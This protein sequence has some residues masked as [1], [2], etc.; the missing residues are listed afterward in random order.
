[1]NSDDDHPHS[2]PDDSTHSQAAAGGSDEISLRAQALLHSRA[3]EMAANAVMI[4]DRSGRISWVNPA[5]MT[6]TGYS[7]E[8]VRGRN[9]RLLKSGKHSR[10]YYASL[11]QTILAGR[12]WRG[13][14][15]NRRKDGSDYWDEHT[16][17]PVRTEGG[18]ITH[19]VAIM[20]DVTD[21][22]RAER[23]VE[24]RTR[25]ALLS[26]EIA[27]AFTRAENL[28]D[29]LRRCTD[30]IAL[31]LQ[32]SLVRV[33]TLNTA[34]NLLEM[35]ASS[36]L[37][38]ALDGPYSRVP[39]GQPK[40]G[41]VALERRPLYTDDL[42]HDP[43]FTNP[44]WA[45]RE[46]LTSFAAY[47]L[48]VHDQLL[49]VVAIFAR[50]PLPEFSRRGLAAVADQMAVGL[51]HSHALQ[52]LRES[53]E[54]YRDLFESANDLIQST[55]PHGFI[56]YAN[57]AWRETLGYQPEDLGHLRFLDVVHPDAR[58]EAEELLARANRGEQIKLIE[59]DFITR[60]RSRIAVEGSV[61]TKTVFGR[62]VSVRCIFRNVTDKK[63]LET[64]FLRH[65]RMESLG[66]LAGGIA[67]DL[68]N[69]LAPIL[70][71]VGLLRSKFT[72]PESQ[73]ILD[74][75]GAS[76]QR[77]ADMVKQVLTFSRGL[78]GKRAPVQLQHLLQDMRWI[79][80]QTFPKSIVLDT[81][82]WRQPL[83]AV[84]GDATQLHQ[85]L[86]NLCVNA[87]DAM[88]EGG[89]LTL[90]AENVVV[91]EAL[92][93]AHQDA[94]PGPYV[95][96]RVADTGTGIPPEALNRIFE[97]FFTTKPLGEGTGLGLSTVQR[98]VEIH[99]GFLTVHT[100]V[101]AGTEFKV[102]LPAQAS[103][104]AH[105]TNKVTEALPAGKGELILVVDDEASVR[106][107]TQETLETFGYRVISA[108]DGAS[109][110]GLYSQRG[111]EVSLILMDL[112]MPIM[113]G[114]AAIRAIRKLQPRIRVIAASGLFAEHPSD[115]PE[116]QPNARLH[117][118][119]TAD[120]LLKLI[121]EV[122]DHPPHSPSLSED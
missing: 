8:E 113:D 108:N 112:M 94:K 42:Q 31:Q 57:R 13:E 84:L 110:V 71:S 93:N 21:R 79:M 74:L 15:V 109:A 118:P 78:E 92:A 120:Q 117:K 35:Q 119:F 114:V 115:D 55:S 3:L 103:R 48:I 14:F 45:R 29:T 58:Q 87:R 36:G 66:S 26:A 81:L 5:F 68:N 56:I 33:W 50:H 17:T 70:M 60:A 23:E 30:S 72:D 4:T 62:V 105:S 37:L 11:W 52:A 63:K 83:G 49:G 43:S 73:S 90:D 7:G 40:I 99:G 100:T 6:L 86:M 98:V 20:L 34:G 116:S 97:P 28:L 80:Q 106:N 53:E 122:L 44:E 24:E 1:M 65:Q 104:P 82:R 9:P 32:A 46:G 41:R 111:E 12:T 76:A 2:Q 39:V 10:E 95:M 67:H 89:T 38:T 51:Q 121:R 88:P 16:I 77:G 75:L 25:L 85:I 69:A 18:A 47:P 107:V 64:Q 27:A 54:Q 101:G 102:Y 96:L 22:K 19:F 91:D 61:S 59:L